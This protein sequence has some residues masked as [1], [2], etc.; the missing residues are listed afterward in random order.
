MGFAARRSAAGG[1]AFLLAASW[2]SL[3]QAERGTKME[4]A[5]YGGWP[6]CIRMSNGTVELMW[7]GAPVLEG[8]N[9]DFVV[10]NL[11]YMFDSTEAQ[12]AVLSNTDALDDLYHSIEAAKSIRA[13]RRQR[14]DAQCVQQQASDPDPG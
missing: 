13:H 4:K 10:F 9:S 2:V 14:R 7:V 6:N 11:P 8:F 12:G 3:A 5:A 1:L